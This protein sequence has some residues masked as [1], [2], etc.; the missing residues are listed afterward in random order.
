[1]PNYRIF[2]AFTLAFILGVFVTLHDKGGGTATIARAQIPITAQEV[3]FDNSGCAMASTNTQTALEELHT[4]NCAASALNGAEPLLTTSSTLTGAINELV[5]RL[6]AAEG[7]KTAMQNKTANMVISGSDIYFR[8]IN[9]Q[10]RNGLGGSE[11]INGLGNLIIGYDED[12]GGD[13]KTGS[14]NIVVGKGHTYTNYCGFVAG[15]NNSITG[16]F[17]SVTGGANCTAAGNFSSVC[18][19][20][21]NVAEGYCSTI[22]GGYNN[23]A[24]EDTST[25]SGGRDLVTNNGVDYLPDI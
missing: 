20:H 11:T 7:A 6:A 3:A 12:T 24:I 16:S 9:V 2:L 23:R 19:G 8:A 17:A 21:S 22:S 14:H 15:E 13:T 5:A 4:N 1:M 25:I 10:I 18:G